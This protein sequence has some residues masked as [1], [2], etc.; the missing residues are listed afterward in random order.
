MIKERYSVGGVIGHRQI[1]FVFLEFLHS[2]VK[3]S[4]D[5]FFRSS[6]LV[7]SVLERLFLL[8]YGTEGECNLAF[9]VLQLV[10]KGNHLTVQ[11]IS[12][13][14][15]FGSIRACFPHRK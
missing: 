15:Q 14:C 13:A 2:A 11:G 12:F 9:R 5:A 8:R 7:Q 3:L 10:A 6:L 4:T 1:G